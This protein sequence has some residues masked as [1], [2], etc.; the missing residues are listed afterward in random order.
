VGLVFRG[1]V[2]SPFLCNY[3]TD[4]EKEA[5]LSD[6]GMKPEQKRKRKKKKKT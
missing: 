4:I 6:E 5:D 3:A 1:F 2:C